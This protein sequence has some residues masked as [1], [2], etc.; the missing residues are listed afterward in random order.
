M[1]KASVHFSLFLIVFV[2]C[3]FS[4]SLFLSQGKRIKCSTAQAKYRLF[5]GN[6]P[7]NWKEED[8]RKVVAEVGPGVTAVQL[9]KVS[10]TAITVSLCK[11]LFGFPLLGL[12]GYIIISCH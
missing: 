12:L 3:H 9:V 11:Y 1:L 10:L 4:N 5:L 7:R 2:E 8:L 6:I